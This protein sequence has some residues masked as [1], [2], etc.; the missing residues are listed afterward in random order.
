MKTDPEHLQIV[1]GMGHTFIRYKDT[2]SNPPRFIYID[3][4]IA[5]FNA[6]FEGIFVGT[7]QDLQAIAN[8]QKNMNGYKLNLGDYLGS[9]YKNKGYT[10]PPLDIEKQLM[11]SVKGGTRKFSQTRKTKRRKTRR[12]PEKQSPIKS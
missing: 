8:R 5:Q 3:P 10:L 4:T 9:N 1:S 12:G 7:I 6:T 11:E 2:E